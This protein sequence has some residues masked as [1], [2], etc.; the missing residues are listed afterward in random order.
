MIFRTGSKRF[1]V[2]LAVVVEAA[3]TWLPGQPAS[4]ETQA[5]KDR[6]NARETKD[7]HDRAVQANPAVN[8]GYGAGQWGSRPVFD[9]KK[10][11]LEYEEFLKYVEARHR[12]IDRLN[13]E[14]SDEGRAQARAKEEA[15]RALKAKVREAEFK[16]EIAA[17][18]AREERN[19]AELK[20]RAMD[21]VQRAKA[22]DAKNL[23]HDEAMEMA[24]LAE[25][26]VT[27]ALFHG[28]PA[29]ALGVDASWPEREALGLKLYGLAGG[30]SGRERGAINPDFP[31][32]RRAVPIM[33]LAMPAALVKGGHGD[34]VVRQTR[35]L[36][37][38]AGT[39]PRI[40]MQITLGLAAALAMPN[41][42]FTPVQRK[43]AAGLLAARMWKIPPSTGKLEDLDGPALS[44]LL[45]AAAK[46]TPELARAASLN[47]H[48]V[49]QATWGVWHTE[50]K[51]PGPSDDDVA[52]PVTAE[53]DWWNLAGMLVLAEKSRYPGAWFASM[54]TE[55]R[56]KRQ[57]PA[58]A[59][60]KEAVQLA[61]NEWFARNGTPPEVREVIQADCTL[62]CDATAEALAKSAGW[63]AFVLSF[64]DYWSQEPAVNG[65]MEA[66]LASTLLKK[67][68]DAGRD[69]PTGSQRWLVDPLWQPGAKAVSATWRAWLELAG[70]SGIVALAERSPEHLQD[71]ALFRQASDTIRLTPDGQLNPSKVIIANALLRHATDVTD[72]AA[73]N[74]IAVLRGQC[75]GD[76]IGLAAWLADPR[77]RP[78][79]GDPWQDLYE[80]A[81]DERDQVAGKFENF[82]LGPD[83]DFSLCRRIETWLKAVLT[84]KDAARAALLAGTPDEVLVRPDLRMLGYDVERGGL[85]TRAMLLLATPEF[86][87]RLP[88]KNGGRYDPEP[89]LAAV[90]KLPVSVSAEELSAQISATVNRAWTE[91]FEGNKALDSTFSIQAG[92]AAQRALGRLASRWSSAREPAQEEVLKLLFGVLLEGTASPNPDCIE[93]RIKWERALMKGL[94]AADAFAQASYGLRR[95]ELAYIVAVSK[96]PSSLPPLVLPDDEHFFREARRALAKLAP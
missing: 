15:K 94:N 40:P 59:G 16:A 52:Y 12:E 93:A 14:N 74:T 31:A 72:S 69:D 45:L 62:A 82:K 86:D 17:D 43:Q 32:V 44:W 11:Q 53:G 63:D 91:K 4:T 89:W 81:N 92:V 90:A 47:A 95:P 70:P 85:A 3:V 87:P 38:I 80:R 41:S 18:K 33:D 29:T 27:N 65:R 8:G 71:P 57:E 75:Q 55:R 51:R 36:R 42:D 58:P 79:D 66:L 25:A 39:D 34:I 22:D 76:W 54:R 24:A 56:A 64:G 67:T 10:E 6:Y 13:Y 5:N 23:T 49:A 1:L 48:F 60:A 35:A 46:K 96:S 30:V 20:R 61:L 77:R 2:A 21:I 73:V 9:S 19:T 28:R 68:L 83:E 7:A 78:K 26:I 37:A 50:F 84:A 88:V